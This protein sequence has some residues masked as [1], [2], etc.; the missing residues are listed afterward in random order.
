MTEEKTKKAEEKNEEKENIDQK[1]QKTADSEA[2]ES[3][4]EKDESESKDKP[5]ASVKKKINKLSLSEIEAK[6]KE[7]KK[8]MGGWDSKYAQHLQERKKILSS[9]RSE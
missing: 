4:E 2:P 3:K 7:I 8:T 6:L 5:A 1:T 9:D